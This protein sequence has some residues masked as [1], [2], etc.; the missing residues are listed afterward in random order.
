[1]NPMNTRV[2][3]IDPIMYLHAANCTQAWHMLLDLLSW[4][5]GRFVLYVLFQIFLRV[6]MATLIV[7]AACVTCG[8]A[9]C[10]FAIPYVGTVVLLPIFA[11]ER[12]YSAYYL[13]QY[14]PQFNVFA[15]PAQ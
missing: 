1:M 9:C 6:A 11:F 5:Q 2:S 10:F 7:G 4:N 12:S 8:C 15:P 3:V 14:G 13:A